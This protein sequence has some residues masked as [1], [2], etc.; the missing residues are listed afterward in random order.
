MLGPAQSLHGHYRKSHFV[1]SHGPALH[2][3]N[4]RGSLTT[5]NARDIKLGQKCMHLRLRHQ[6]CRHAIKDQLDEHL[7]EI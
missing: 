2:A 7:F 3:Q 1:Q 4:S 6:L 5:S